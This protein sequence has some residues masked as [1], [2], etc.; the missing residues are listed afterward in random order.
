MVLIMYLCTSKLAYSEGEE[1]II[2]Q[3]LEGSRKR[4]STSAAGTFPALL[5]FCL[6]VNTEQCIF[7]FYLFI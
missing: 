3:N 2:Y 5:A 1:R 7:F 6:Q 4:G